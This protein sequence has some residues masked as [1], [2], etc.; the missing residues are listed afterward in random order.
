MSIANVG[1][2]D[3]FLMGV[4]LPA[5]VVDTRMDESFK[6]PFEMAEVCNT[7]PAI[8]LQDR[9]VDQQPSVSQHATVC[10]SACSRLYLSLQS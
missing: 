8:S 3:L 7:Q 6:T 2:I 5:L 9:V 1:D 4:L 10:I